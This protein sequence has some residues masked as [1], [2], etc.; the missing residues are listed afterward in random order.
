MII[1]LNFLKTILRCYIV[2]KIVYILYMNQV[3]LKD[4]NQFVWWILLL[5]FDVWLNIV[6]GSHYNKEGEK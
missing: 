4:L 3:E 1:F 6:F 5:V 2:F